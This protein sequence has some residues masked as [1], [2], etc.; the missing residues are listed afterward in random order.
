MSCEG[1]MQLADIGTNNVREDE[2]IHMLGYSMV[3]LEHSQNT[4]QV[5]VTGYKRV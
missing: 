5:K 4:F 3:R 2:L 1:S